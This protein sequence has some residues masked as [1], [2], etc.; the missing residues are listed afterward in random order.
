ME[1]DRA[2]GEKHLF[3]KNAL[4]CKEKRHVLSSDHSEFQMM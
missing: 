3:W 1:Q 4:V 2:E